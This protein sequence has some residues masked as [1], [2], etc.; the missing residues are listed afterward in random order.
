MMYK[1]IVVDDEEMIREGIVNSVPWN[2]MGFE[3]VGVAGNGLEALERIKIHKPDIVLTDIRMPEMNGIELIEHL[4]SNY[5]D[6]VLL[7]LS[8]YSEVG[9]LKQ[10]IKNKVTDYLFK[11]S[12]YEEFTEVFKKLRSFLDEEKKKQI[13]SNKLKEQLRDSL[14]YMR[15]K[16]LNGLVHGRYKNYKSILR[17]IEYYGVGLMGEAFIAAI[18]EIDNYY[19]LTKDYSEERKEL[20]KYSVQNISNEIGNRNKLGFFF[21]GNNDEIVGILDS[22]ASAKA[23]TTAIEEIQENILK[24][25]KST[26]SAGIGD[27]CTD[28]TEIALSYRRA[29]LALSQKTFLG[30]ES[31]IFYKDIENLENQDHPK[32]VFDTDQIVNI[33]FYGR[34]GEIRGALEQVFEKFEHKLIKQ[35]DYI[36]KLCL[37]LLFTISRHA[38]AMN[39]RIEEIM[40]SKNSSFLEIYKLDSIY[41]KKTWLHDILM[42]IMN[43]VKDLKN[44]NASKLIEEVKKYMTIHFA[45][46]SISLEMVAEKVNKNSAYL[47]K[48]F[49]I[50]TGENF[51]DYLTKLRIDKAKELLADISVKAYEV[52]KM[53]GYAD[54]SHF[55]KVFKRVTG[56]NPS[57][58]RELIGKVGLGNE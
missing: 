40:D 12:N 19:L 58:Y 11:P 43:R 55:T 47:S 17:K 24:I 32:Y 53:V 18:I 7:I 49:K 39:I 26:I 3:V 15:E 52:S 56:I 6:M 48:L 25:T 50:E 33:V 28:I 23:I 46:N 34:E 5:P 54:V 9:Y 31:L 10:A 41:S 42:D 14:P 21:L 35:N 57:E 4:H 16:F 1:L 29:V 13:E 8:G 22:N 27:K 45:N 2:D 37:E 36:D 44:N 38:Q 51:I 30:T 20:L